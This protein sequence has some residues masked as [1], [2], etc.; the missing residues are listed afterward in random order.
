MELNLPISARGKYEKKKRRKNPATIGTDLTALNTQRVVL[1]HAYVL[2][3]QNGTCV[4][5]AAQTRI[6]SKHVSDLEYH[7]VID[8]ITSHLCLLNL[9][10]SNI[11]SNINTFCYY[12]LIDFQSC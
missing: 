11:C 6:L 4:L 5:S 10:L 8:I 7:C 12:E 3:S 1:T 2:Q 9:S